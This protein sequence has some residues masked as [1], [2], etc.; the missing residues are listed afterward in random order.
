M[1]YI[2]NKIVYYLYYVNFLI[3]FDLFYIFQDLY[4]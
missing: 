3:Y 1:S 4:I 2:D